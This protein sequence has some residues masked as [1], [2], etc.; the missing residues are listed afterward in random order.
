MMKNIPNNPFFSIITCTYNSEKFLRNNLNSVKDQ[1]FKDYEHVFI[2][3]CSN[4]DTGKIIESYKKHNPEFV[5]VFQKKPIGIS[6]AMNEGIKRARGK[7]LIYLHSDDYFYDDRVLKD[8]YTFLKKNNFPDW[9]YGK[10]QVVEAW[11]KEVGVFPKW[12]IFQLSNPTLLKLF[13]YIPHQA[14]FMKKTILSKFGGFDEKLK[15]SMDCD[16]WLRLAE[17]THWIF[18]DRII[19]NYT[20]HKGSQS[21]DK[22]NMSINN[23]E[24]N[25]VIKR[26]L[27]KVEY[28]LHLLVRLPLSAYNHT[29]R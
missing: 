21:S 12:R 25:K 14:V 4:D 11:G 16:L 17:K 20:I 7:Y 18:I 2:D 26:R 6:D 10:I 13:N 3:G 28:F 8:E 15:S 22:D 27:N 19:S 24:L 5:K 9:V 29:R 23:N 1:S